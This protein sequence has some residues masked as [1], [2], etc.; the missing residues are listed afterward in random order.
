MVND[1]D[2]SQ[3]A[4]VTVTIINAW[5]TAGKQRMVT[6]AVLLDGEPVDTGTIKLDDSAH[7]AKVAYEIAGHNDAISATVLYLELARLAVEYEFP[8]SEE[9]SGLDWKPQDFTELANGRR[10]VD[11]HGRNVRFTP[12]RGWFVWDNTRFAPDKLETAKTLVKAVNWRIFADANDSA[13]SAVQKALLRFGQTSVSTRGIAATLESA[14]T[15]PEIMASLDWFDTDP[16][17]L[18]VANA[19]IDLRTGVAREHRRE[20]NLTKCAPV[21]YEPDA[22]CPL[23]LR[24]VNR[25]MADSADKVAYLQRAAGYSLTGNTNEHILFLCYGA[26]RN[27]KGTFME[28]FLAML[29]DYARTT[30]FETFLHKEQGSGIPNDIAAMVGARFVTASEAPQGRRLA[31]TT[32]KS[33]TGGD[34]VSA[35]FLH[36]EF[37]AYQ[38]QFKIWLAANHK[39]A[40]N[41]TTE[42]FWSRIRLI[43]FTVQIPENERILN[44][45]EQLRAEWPGILN[46]ALAGCADW[47]TRGLATPDEIRDATGAYRMEND[48]IGAFMAECLIVDTRGTASVGATYEAYQRWAEDSAERAITKRALSARL[49]ERGFAVELVGKASTKT[50]AGFRLVGGAFAG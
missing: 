17:L 30:A 21:M 47:Q 2:N 46:W 33:L 11:A 14:R 4:E 45:K 12:E 7:R 43:P 10:F 1:S 34:M 36:R 28:T 19:T 40:A 6:F 41:E 5:E 18:N 25:A 27:G 39:P 9:G 24:V 3:T 37:F 20:D 31:E 42:G 22:T 26:G 35:R 23:F 16:M 49:Q 38:P 48:A 29:G 44:L 8:T 32:I 50:W 13:D 15:E